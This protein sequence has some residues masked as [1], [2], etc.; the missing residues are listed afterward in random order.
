MVSRAVAEAENALRV[1]LEAKEPNYAGFEPLL[2]KYIR[3]TT[4]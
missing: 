3:E 2:E 4:F 1:T